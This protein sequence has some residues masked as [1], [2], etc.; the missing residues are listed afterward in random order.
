MEKCKNGL[1]SISEGRELDKNKLVELALW[2]VDCSSTVSCRFKVQ[3]TH[4]LRGPTE[5]E[6]GMGQ[7]LDLTNVC[8]QQATNEG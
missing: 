3:Y 5:A 4:I 1:K 2:L 8:P 6:Q 7:R